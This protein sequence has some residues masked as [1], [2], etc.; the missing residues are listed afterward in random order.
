[1]LVHAAGWI[2][3]LM[4]RIKARCQ[5]YTAMPYLY[6]VGGWLVS[7]WGVEVRAAGQSRVGQ[8]LRVLYACNGRQEF[9]IKVPLRGE[10]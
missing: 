5:F 3:N 6:S 9:L 8:L 1:M 7:T 2:R 4:A 10:A